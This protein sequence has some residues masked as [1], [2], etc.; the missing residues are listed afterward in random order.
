Y[1]EKFACPEHPEVSLPELEPR[2]FSFNSP[3]GAC[4]NCHGLGTTCEFDAD[5]IVADP[6]LSIE[7]GAV[8]AW[9]RN[10]KR[11]NIYYSRVLRQFCRDY[12][13]SYSAPFESIP[14]KIQQVLMFGSDAKGDAGTGTWFE[15]VIPNLQRRFENT[16]SEFV[17]A[18]L[19]Q[20]MSEQPCATCLGTRLRKEALCVRLEAEDEPVEARAPDEKHTAGPSCGVRIA[21]AKASDVAAGDHSKNGKKK[22]A[23]KGKSS[24]ETA[25]PDTANVPAVALPGFSIH[26]VSMM[27]VERAKRFF[28]RLRLGE[29]GE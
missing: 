8:E 14:K 18:R 20:Y 22:P 17:K 26:D 3:H 10:G 23:S 2:L 4:P 1:S 21:E 12:G 5:M 9:R 19:H 29:E 6:S 15:G 16:E 7:N 27:T 13:I 25:P 11:M 28:D 24:K